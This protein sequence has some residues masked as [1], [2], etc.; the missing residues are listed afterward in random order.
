M[1]RKVKNT[2]ENLESLDDVDT[3]VLTMK[4]LQDFCVRVHNA[5]SRAE[6][7]CRSLEI[8]RN[9]LKTMV[10]IA[11]KQFKE[12]KESQSNCNYR[13]Q[14]EIESHTIGKYKIL[15]CLMNVHRE[16]AEDSSNQILRFYQK[17]KSVELDTLEKMHKIEGD[18]S[19]S[20]KIILSKHTTSK[21]TIKTL[22]INLH[23]KK[24]NFLKQIEKNKDLFEAQ[25]KKRTK[26]IIKNLLD[27][28]AKEQKNLSDYKNKKIDEYLKQNDKFCTFL[29]HYYEKIKDHNTTIL[30]TSY[31]D[32]TMSKNKLLLLKNSLKLQKQNIVNFSQKIKKHKKENQLLAY[33][34]I[35]CTKVKNELEQTLYQKKW[36]HNKSENLRWDNLLLEEA[37]TIYEKKQAEQ[38]R[39]LVEN[40]QKLEIKITEQWVLLESLVDKLL[41]HLSTMDEVIEFARLKQKFWNKELTFDQIKQLALSSLENATDE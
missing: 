38:N 22:E 34:L 41:A 4:Q 27:K 36:Y 1:A 3:Y 23:I 14:R 32:Y 20:K 12:A 16:L 7:E 6:V 40:F 2:D 9:T 25:H 35:D 19:M 18:I 8:E 31:D 15:H 13:L 5:K 39:K 28:S 17:L 21:D 37:C 24:S 11:M 26:V 29:R 33:E 10:D 30:E